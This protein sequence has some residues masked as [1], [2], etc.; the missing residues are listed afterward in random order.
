[1][2]NLAICQIFSCSEWKICIYS[3]LGCCSPPGSPAILRVENSLSE[4]WEQYSLSNCWS[5]WV[6]V[7][8]PLQKLS[9]LRLGWCRVS[10]IYI[11]VNMMKVV[12]FF[13][14]LPIAMLF[15]FNL[16][17]YKVIKERMKAFSNLNERKKRDV[18]T[19]KVLCII[20]VICILCNSLRTVLNLLEMF[21]S[22]LVSNKDIKRTLDDNSL[23]QSLSVASNALIIINSSSNF[24]VYFFYDKKYEWKTL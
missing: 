8:Y 5:Y 3:D 11:F 10:S 2:S 9:K 7:C 24:F 4:R 19:S 20:V 12:I 16:K 6:K 23:V 15:F 14:L 21:A 17:I 22:C 13:N 18:I 1:M